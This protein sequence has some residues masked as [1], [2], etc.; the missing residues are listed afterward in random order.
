MAENFPNLGRE[1]DTQIQEAQR[2]QRELNQNTLPLNGNKDKNFW[3][4]QEKTEITK[5]RTLKVDLS[6]ET[7][8]AWKQWE[9][10]FKILGAKNPQSF[11]PDLYTQW[12]RPSEIK[13]R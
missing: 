11:N 9:D 10:I 6:T 8:Q 7:F 2:T 3:K 1:I 4:Q 13:E 12:R 5:K